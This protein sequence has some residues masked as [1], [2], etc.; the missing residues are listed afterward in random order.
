MIPEIKNRTKAMLDS[1]AEALD[2][3]DDE[4]LKRP[5]LGWPV[6]KQLYHILYWLDHWFIDPLEFKDPDFHEAEF[7][8]TNENSSKTLTKAQLADYFLEIRQRIEKYVSDITIE[9]LMEEQ[10]VR[11]DS[12]TRLD[13]ILGQFNH[14]SHHIG[15]LRGLLRALKAE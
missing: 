1:I 12:R 11:G 15:Y 10:K 14:V 6:W 2:S 3:V 5:S 7:M 13:M 4:T 9:K 8:E